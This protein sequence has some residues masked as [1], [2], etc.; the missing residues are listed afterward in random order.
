[1]TSTTMR[2]E[3]AEAITEINL[4]AK[5]I[6]EN[7]KARDILV[8]LRY[9]TRY[10]QMLNVLDRRNLRGQTLVD[11]VARNHDADTMRLGSELESWLVEFPEDG[12]PAGV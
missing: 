1:M 7:S 9:F 8:A 6:E 2:V 4:L 11:Y 10:T 3:L 12:R 5:L